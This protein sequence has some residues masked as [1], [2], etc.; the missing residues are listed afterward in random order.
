M[1]FQ[2]AIDGPSGAGKSTVAREAARKLGFAYIDTGKLYR[3]IGL[4]SLKADIPRQNPQML[5]AFLPKIPLRV[6]FA[7]DGLR[8]F[9]GETDVE[10]EIRTPAASLAASDVAAHPAV[11]AYL[12]DLQRNLAAKNDCILDGRDIGT[13]VLPNAALKIFLTANAAER[14][15]RRFAELEQRGCPQPLSDVLEEIV[16]RDK[17]D[18]ERALAPLRAASDAVLLDSTAL[19]RAQVVTEVIRLVNE[20]RKQK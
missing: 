17:R 11:R 5:A 12:M 13:V 20:R 10:K 14:A 15:H 2:V 4:A 1:T 7:Q 3:A 19:S 8:V 16:L 18:S 6:D 9:L